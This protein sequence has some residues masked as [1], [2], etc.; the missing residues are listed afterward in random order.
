MKTIYIQKQWPFSVD[1][2]IIYRYSGR[3]LKIYKRHRLRNKLTLAVFPPTTFPLLFR[4]GIKIPASAA[5][6]TFLLKCW[7]CVTS[8]LQRLPGSSGSGLLYQ[9]FLHCVGMGL[10]LPSLCRHGTRPFNRPFFSVWVHGTRPFFTVWVHGTR[11][12][13]TVGGWMGL[14]LS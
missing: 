4:P 9:A 13:L 7:L 8:E 14:G 6:A 1:F 5:H 3:Y 10:G 11:P 2:M 12:F